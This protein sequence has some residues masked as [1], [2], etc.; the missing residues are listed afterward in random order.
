M[1][2]LDLPDDVS[3]CIYLKWLKRCYI[4]RLDNAFCNKTLRTVFHNQL[5]TISQFEVA[6]DHSGL[7][8]LFLKSR[9]RTLCFEW[10]LLRNIKVTV[11]HFTGR[12]I[13]K[14]TKYES[15]DYQRYLLQLDFSRVTSIYVG[16][17][18]LPDDDD[19]DVV[20]EDEDDDDKN[21]DDEKS[22]LFG[23]KSSKMLNPFYD[24]EI[25]NLVSNCESLTALYF[26]DNS[27]SINMIHCA[28]P[29]F[30]RLTILHF[31]CGLFDTKYEEIFDVLAEYC[32]KL[33]SLWI[34]ADLVLN[35]LDQSWESST[36]KVIIV[37]NPNL[38]NFYMCNVDVTEEL[39]TYL[40]T[41]QFKELSLVCSCKSN[42]NG[43][44]HW[45]SQL[46]M[47]SCKLDL[48]ITHHNFFCGRL[49]Y[50]NESK[51]LSLIDITPQLQYEDPHDICSFFRDIQPCLKVVI[52]E[53]LMIDTEIL[54]CLGKCQSTLVEI[55]LLNIGIN[56]MALYQ[57]DIADYVAKEQDYVAAVLN[58]YSRQCKSL[59]VLQIV[60][61][62]HDEN[63][64][65]GD[66]AF[67]KLVES[68]FTGFND[69][70][71]IRQEDGRL[72]EVNLADSEKKYLVKDDNT[73]RVLSVKLSK[74]IL[75]KGTLHKESLLKK[76]LFY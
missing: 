11:V 10:L 60:V 6:N 68:N 62:D 21:D 54:V 13:R 33:T 9:I 22:R 69:D 30:K 39:V 76:T 59:E 70:C 34:K 7:T 49:I 53:N 14:K 41:R 32:H 17:R 3:A 2:I 38:V 45:W 24:T 23:K 48:D 67:G 65:E 73:R 72:V 4:Q 35:G 15:R 16:Y 75:C 8:K 57:L 74:S 52:L 18:S 1:N 26:E 29:A 56:T 46:L 12:I 51:A 27:L 63:F 66:P 19:Y 5:S 58:L 36:V 37:A 44:I 40:A 28:S 42:V 64:V 55:R 47:D 25:I 43:S 50:E 71:L 61:G 31:D 20:D